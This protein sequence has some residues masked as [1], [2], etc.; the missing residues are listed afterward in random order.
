MDSV[1][2][3]AFEQFLSRHCAPARVRT[4]EVD[5]PRVAAA[6]LWRDVVD[7][8][9]ADALVAERHG[10]AG[11]DLRAAETIA[12]ACGRHAMPL[13]LSITVLVRA[14]LLDFGV[15]APE[16]SITV[17]MAA[18]LLDGGGLFCAAVP[19]GF[20]ADGCSS[21]RQRR[22]GCYRRAKPCEA[23][24]AGTARCRRTCSGAPCRVVRP[25]RN[26]AM[27]TASSGVRSRQQR[28]PAT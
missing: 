17:A 15:P 7:S 24:R 19:Y 22:K 21:K 18:R 16:G 20:T 10:G 27:R 28:L 2:S 23:A 8:G 11:L 13:P 6:A 3:N 4:I 5:G 9:F 25:N 26:A 1:L 12:F 14:A